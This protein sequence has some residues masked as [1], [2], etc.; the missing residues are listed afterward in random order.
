MKVKKFYIL[1]ALIL[2]SRT[3]Y[4]VENVTVDS[5]SMRILQRGE[6]VEFSGNVSVNAPEV[7]ATA[8]QALMQR[9]GARVEA[10]GNVE[11]YYSSAALNFTGW[12]ENLVYDRPGE[13]IQMDGNVKIVYEPEDDDISSVIYAGRAHIDLSKEGKIRF[14][15]DVRAQRGDVKIVSGEAVYDRQKEI[16][17]FT[18]EPRA[19]T[20]AEDFFIDY[21]GDEMVFSLVDEEVLIKG[22]AS[23]RIKAHDDAG[24]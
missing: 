2:L 1:G 8:Q 20:R 15:S 17:V 24:M 14:T 22:N 23:T 3:L 11:L 13:Y 19:F 9:E 16:F 21:S 12:C 10:S 6:V 18:L 7:R 5:D 4:A